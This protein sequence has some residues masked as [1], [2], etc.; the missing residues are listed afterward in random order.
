MDNK[1]RTSDIE[2]QKFKNVEEILQVGEINLEYQKLLVFAIKLS[3][4]N[5]RSSKKRQYEIAKKLLIL[6]Q[7]D[8]GLFFFYNDQ[9]VFRFSF[10]YSVPFY[11]RIEYSHYKRHTYFISP[12]RPSKTFYEN[13][14]K[15]SF[16]NL[17]EIKKAFSVYP[18][19]KQFFTEVQ[20]WY[21]WALRL[22]K[23]NI[24]YFPGGKMEENLIRL[25]TRL[26]F[27][28][29]L[30][31]KGL[32]PENI[33]DAGFITKVVKD[34]PNGDSYYNVILQNLFFATLNNEVGERE[35]AENSDFLRNRVQYGVKT[36]Y[37]YQDR[38]LISNQDFIN[39]FERV[40]FINGGLF[41]CLD[42]DEE[43]IDGFS[44]NEKRRAV[45]PDYLFFGD[46]REEDL[47]EFYG[48]KKILKVRGLINIF[49]DY[50]FTVDESS[51]VDVEVSLD[52]ELLGNVFENL[53]AS[54]N[55]ETSTTARKSTGS[56][57]TPKE[58]VDLMVDESLVEYFK[59]RTGIEERK[60]VKLLSYSDEDVDLSEEERRAIVEGVEGLKV[61]D[62]AV[63][64]GAF[65]V[66]MLHKLVHLLNKVDPDNS[67]WFDIQLEK[68]REDIRVVSELW[69]EREKIDINQD[70]KEIEKDFDELLNYP[71]YSRKLYIIQNCLYGVDIQPIAIQICKLRFFL[72]LL[73]D[74][75][76][77][78]T[79]PN[80][81]I[82]P[83]P[84]LET[85]FVAANTLIRLESMGVL[86]FINQ[87]IRKLREELK[88]IYKKH[89]SVK[90]RTQKKRL[91]EKAKQIRE[92]MKSLLIGTRIN[93]E[94]IERIANFDIFAQHHQ[95]TEWFDPVWMFA[96]DRKFDVV[97]GN[98]PY[99]RQEKIRDIKDILR[100][101]KYEV[102]D[103]KADIYVYFFER[104]IN[105]LEDR[106]ILAF[107]SS[108]K[109]M[110]ASYGAKLRKVLKEKNEI[111]KIIDFGGYPVFEQSVDTCIVILKKKMAEKEHE[112]YF[113]NVPSDLKDHSDAIRYVYQN[114]NSMLQKD[115]ST[116]ILVLEDRRILGIKE[117]IERIGKPLKY[118]NVKIYRGV[119]TGFNEAFIIDSQTRE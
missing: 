63:G 20:N 4:L 66:G 38:L 15:C 82:R 87:E 70:K 26:I 86:K 28:W 35:F 25:I 108:N 89:F 42:E 59:D 17:D 62:P 23:Q 51:P 96:I 18:L 55:P 36:L 88:L 32:V 84:H 105:L 45:L 117:K 43:Y 50:N 68:A 24:V 99:V 92:R 39:I 72:S 10:V 3:D 115:I 113:V 76:V 2:S 119:I 54:Y 7:I 16:S 114:Q 64:S 44:R 13:M 109:W 30:K 6:F 71:D 69:K 19:T 85:K 80:F 102:F 40:P 46:Y 27:V 8:A 56:Y 83:L 112:F 103:P 93:N 5:E 1:V 61:L 75:R 11:S 81:G 106:G 107:I 73:I 77:D 90:T 78:F 118:W 21:A 31:E 33:F 41:V 53:L 104:G 116:D 34:F 74:Q 100:K 97:I 101:Q 14:L 52:P 67:L 79:R 65:L 48:E 58:I 91:Q 37:R 9:K 60:L 111:V 110:R 98:P 12:G 95:S 22:S 94:E 47:S 29:F 57:Y 49:K